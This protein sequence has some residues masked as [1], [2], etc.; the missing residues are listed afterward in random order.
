MGAC[1]GGTMT[2]NINIDVLD[3]NCSAMNGGP[4][5]FLM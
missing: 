3:A 1:C 5:F 4:M 2:I